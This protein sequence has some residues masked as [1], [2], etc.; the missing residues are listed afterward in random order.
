MSRRTIHRL[1]AADLR[2]KAPGT[3]ADGGGLLLQISAGKHGP[4][5]SWIFR[6]AAD[7]RRREMGLGSTI[8]I[9]MAE[10]RELALQ[11]R[12]LRLA[13]VD[14]IEQ[15]KAERSARTAAAIK[16]V[17]F[18]ECADRFIAAHRA[19]WRSAKHAAQW[20]VGGAFFYWWLS[21]NR[22]PSKKS[23]AMPTHKSRKTKS[24]KFRAHS[25]RPRFGRIP[26]AAE[27]TGVGRSKIYELGAVT[28]GLLKKLGAATLVDFDVLDQILDALP[29]ADIQPPRA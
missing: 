27:Y 20:P 6:Y 19:G 28:P 7:G 16:A 13:G 14:P 4:N 18:D 17:S 8:T 9:G 3:Y 2:R 29:A 26:A 15:R 12:K 23:H 25:M 22:Q 10:A 1:T 11:C 24:R 21:R 5:R